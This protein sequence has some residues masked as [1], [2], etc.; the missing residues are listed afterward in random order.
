MIEMILTITLA[1]VL[2]ELIRTKRTARR[3]QEDLAYYK[4]EYVT[5][6]C[7][8]IE[9][10][11]LENM[12]TTSNTGRIPSAIPD[13]SLDASVHRCNICGDDMWR[14]RDCRHVPG[15]TYI[16]E[17]DGSDKWREVK[18]VPVIE[19]AEEEGRDQ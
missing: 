7:R 16:I 1:G 13:D 18:C 9:A 3:Y 2:A 10:A 17:E 14:S 5:L 12:R 15:V 11:A 4:K 8:N 19:N 6:R